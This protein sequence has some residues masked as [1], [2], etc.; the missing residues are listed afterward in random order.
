MDPLNDEADKLLSEINVFFSHVHDAATIKWTLSPSCPT[1]ENECMPCN[2]DQGIVTPFHMQHFDHSLETCT[3]IDQQ[4]RA[5]EAPLRIRT[6]NWRSLGFISQWLG[7]VLG[8]QA[9]RPGLRPGVPGAGNPSYSTAATLAIS[10]GSCII[11]RTYRA[12]FGE[13]GCFTKTYWRMI[14]LLTRAMR[15]IDGL[16]RC[17]AEDKVRSREEY[18]DSH[19][20]A[21]K[22]GPTLGE[23]G[24]MQL[25][26]RVSSTGDSSRAALWNIL[27]YLRPTPRHAEEHWCSSGRTHHSVPC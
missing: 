19:R 14:D 20:K 3:R 9:D 27:G 24:S 16:R 5:Y 23:D 1:A 15:I 13:H 17:A 10:T 25:S 6:M 11:N 18:C 2:C 7:V 26:R 8:A 4:N 22:H 12:L 21:P